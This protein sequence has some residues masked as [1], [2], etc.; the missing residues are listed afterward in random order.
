MLPNAVVRPIF[1]GKNRIQRWLA[2]IS[3]LNKLRASEPYPMSAL[4]VAAIRCLHLILTNG[5][6]VLTVRITPITGRRKEA[7]KVA[8][9]EF[10]CYYYR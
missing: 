2:A 3:A 7:Q 4:S 8:N 1:H 10:L 6:V 5:A 9:G